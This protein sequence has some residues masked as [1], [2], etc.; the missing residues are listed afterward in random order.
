[1]IRSQT[2]MVRLHLVR[3]RHNNGLT[4]HLNPN[5]GKI[6]LISQCGDGLQYKFHR[7]SG[8]MNWWLASPKL[9]SHECHFSAENIVG[10]CAPWQSTGRGVE[11]AL[12]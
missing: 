1:M 6:G 8:K 9:G 3:S 12:Q 7:V 10:T 2:V 4:Y 5:H 11:K